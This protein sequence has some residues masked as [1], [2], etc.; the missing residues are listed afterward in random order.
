MLLGQLARA[1]GIALPANGED[2]P[3]TYPGERVEVVIAHKV[4]GGLKTAVVKQVR[5]DDE[6]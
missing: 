2:L 4:K 5:A 3:K 6:W 1:T